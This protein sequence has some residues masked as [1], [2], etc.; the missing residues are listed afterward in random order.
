MRDAHLTEIRALPLFR[1]MGEE[2]FESMT[3]GAYVQTFPPQV[4][5]ITEGDPCDF[6]HIVI[7]GAVELFASWNG[8]ETTMATVL[9]VS[10]L[11]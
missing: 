6:L 3:R 10:T 4:E 8:R 9:P 1:N 11:M 2:A 7:D 5:L